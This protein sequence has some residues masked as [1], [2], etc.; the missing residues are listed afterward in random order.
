MLLNNLLARGW[1]ERH[2]LRVVLGATFL[3]AAALT[4]A[5][6][7][8]QP[9]ASPPPPAPPWSPAAFFV[10]LLD[11]LGPVPFLRAVRPHE[12]APM[13]AIYRTYLDASELLPAARLL[14]PL[15]ARRLPRRLRRPRPPPRRHRPPHPPPPAARNVTRTHARRAPAPSL[16]SSSARN[17]E[18][19]AGGAGAA[20]AKLRRWASAARR[21]RPRSRA[22]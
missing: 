13:T 17:L 2:S 12:R 3:A 11:G 10:A 9:R 4:L 16:P 18:S 7:P 6:G 1:A 19:S 8:A 22:W 5:A 20:S 15:H 14:L 21:G